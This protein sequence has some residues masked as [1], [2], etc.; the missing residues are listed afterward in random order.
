MDAYNDAWVYRL[1]GSHYHPLVIAF[2]AFVIPITNESFI[3]II[4]FA[5]TFNSAITIASIWSMIVLLVC[6]VTGWI[7]QK[8]TVPKYGGNNSFIESVYLLE[9]FEV[10]RCSSWD[11][12]T[13][14]PATA[15]NTGSP[16]LDFGQLQVVL[17]VQLHSDITASSGNGNV[18]TSSHRTSV[19]I[20]PDSAVACQIRT[21]IR[22]K[23]AV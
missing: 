6:S 19:E 18:E 4:S 23:R 14:R 10:A 21:A 5:A 16:R 20:V 15:W 12:E 9:P 7:I 3:C 8:G 11:R 1:L 13:L 22:R 2:T 17:M